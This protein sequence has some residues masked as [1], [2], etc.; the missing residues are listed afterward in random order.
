MNGDVADRVEIT[1]LIARIAHLADEGNPVDY[2]GCFTVDAVWDLADATGLPMGTERIVG[3]AAIHS[4]VQERR[5]AGIQGPGSHT[6]HD[7]SSID[8][9]V[10]GPT[11][12]ARSI[13]RYYRHVDAT[14][15]LVSI[16][17][18]DDDFTLTAEGWLLNHRTIRRL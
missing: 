12:H 14:P 10:E 6:I 8:V 1:M 13:F 7:V 2:A 15:Q 4:G 5:E 16:G 11:A 9:H 17:V 18:Y 3:R